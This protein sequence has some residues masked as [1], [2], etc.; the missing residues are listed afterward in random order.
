MCGIAGVIDLAGRH[1]APRD[2]LRRMADSIAH[3]G[4]DDDGYLDLPHLG[5]ANRRLS[6]IGLADGKQPIANEDRSVWCVFNG[7]VFEYPQKRRELEAKGHRFRT[8]TDTELLPHLWEE[9]CEGLFDHLKGQFAFC[10]YDARRNVLVLARDRF[11]IC[12]L[13]W[14]VRR[15]EG[16]TYLLFASEVRALLASGMV[17]AEPDLHGLNHV[18]TFFGLP[19]PTTCFKG[20]NLLPPGHYLRVR[21]GSD[22]AVEERTYWELDFPDRGHEENPPEREAVAEYERLFVQSVER[23]LRADVPVV[24]YLSGGV[25]SSIV[26]AVASKVLGRPIPTFTVA[27]RE[28]G[29]DESSEAALVARHIGTKPFVADY[30]HREVRDTY[31]DLVAAAEYPVVDT[32]AAALLRLARSVRE[33]GYKV[34]MTGEGSDEFLAGY[35]WFKTHR[36]LGVLGTRAGNRLRSIVLR[37]T[38]Q[39]RFPAHMLRESQEY[40]GG[41]NGWLDLYGIMSLSKLRFY[42][43]DLKRDLIR[44]TPYAE[45]GLNREKMLR[46]HPFHRSIALGARIMLGGHQLASKG[47]RVAMWESVELRPPF[48]D[49]DLVEYTNRLHPR[50]K[51]RRLRDKYL[52][53]KVAEKYVPRQIAW[54]RKK[55]FRAPLDSFH[56]SGSDRPAW[57]DQ[58]LSP[59]ALRK[60]GYFDA[61][62]VAKWR[63]VV[64]HMPRTL[65]RTSV[66]MGLA[67][68]TGT[69]LWHHLF[70]SGDLAELPIRIER[71]PVELA[72]V[73]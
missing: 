43:D 18:F 25:D 22:S 63:A 9:H 16:T 64:R 14:T 72:S 33:H 56:L 62:A 36:L 49:E 20:V 51:L 35:P 29:F 59:E 58:V 7:E 60:T 66:E 27:V 4:P 21:L 3:R 65:K 70:I 34:A 55:M 10:I 13:Y 15:H 39:P 11:G 41:H 30:S 32:S 67:A 12:P 5:L 19:G 26:A 44:Q 38:G 45:L 6:I 37:I 17:P 50:W 57:I 46:W 1:A 40:V 42:S 54:R 52:L 8:H 31:P 48:L 69:Q 23:R 24:S 53:R 68:V 71:R 61:N 73:A 28:R 47:D 2:T